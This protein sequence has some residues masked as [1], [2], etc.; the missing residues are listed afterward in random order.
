[1][2]ARIDVHV[3]PRSRYPIIIPLQPEP[4]DRAYQFLFLIDILTVLMDL[5]LYKS[6]YYYSKLMRHALYSIVH[7][8]TL[9]I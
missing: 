8:I 3:P 9:I 2:H 6:L 1:M 4:I 7:F 5:R